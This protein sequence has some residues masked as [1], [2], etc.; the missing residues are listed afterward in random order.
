MVINLTQDIDNK[1]P[2]YGGFFIVC[3]IKIIPYW[4]ESLV[5][6]LILDV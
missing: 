6:V 4:Q 5:Q 1:K 3:I 2:P